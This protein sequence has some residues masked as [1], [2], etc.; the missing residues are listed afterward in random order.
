[1]SA[2]TTPLRKLLGWICAILFA[3]LVVIVVWQVFT[4]QVLNNPAAWSEEASR[5]VFV[6]LGLFAAALVF[7]ERGHIS[8]DFVARKFGPG[9]QKAIAIVV[10]VLIIVF[11]LWLLVY[12]GIVA[13]AGAFNQH[14]AALRAL[15][16]GQMYMVMPITGVIITLFALENLIDIARGTESA[17]PS[18]DEEDLVTQ[19]EA[20]GSIPSAQTTV[21]IDGVAGPGTGTGATSTGPSG[22]TDGGNDNGAT[23]DEKRG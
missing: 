5:M 21:A 2:I 23:T 8:V 15:T 16:L 9:G 1:M 7:A 12:G 17:F 20:E 22:T 13:G 10:Q 4:R 6:W 18:T 14:L 19:L 11:S 3:A